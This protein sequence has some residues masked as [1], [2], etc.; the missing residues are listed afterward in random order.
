MSVW[1]SPPSLLKLAGQSLLRDEALAIAALEELPRELFPPLFT[2]AFF[3]RHSETLKAMVQAW[4]FPCLPLGVLMKEQQPHQETF[5]AVLDGLD[6]LLAQEV[7]P[8]RWKLQLLDLRKNTHQD[9]WTVW[10]GTKGSVCSLLD[11]EAA[12]PMRKKQKVGDLCTGTEQPLAPVEVLI[13]LALGEGAQDQLLTYLIEK[14]KQRKGLLQL[15]CRKLEIFAMPIHN[16]KMIL[17]LVQLDSIK[18]LEVNCTWKLSTLGKFSPHLGQMS[19]LQ[20]LLLSHV[21]MS[22]SMSLEE[23]EQ[24]VAQFT[25]QFLKLHHLQELYLDS[26]SFLKGRLHQLLRCLKSPLETLSIS[27]CQ[28]SESD[29]TCLSQCPNISQLKELGLSGVNLTNTSPEPLQVLLERTSA[30]LQDLDLDECGI[31][32]AQFITILPTLGRCS[33]LTTFSFCGNP[34]SMAVLESLL[35]YTVG[36]SKLSHVLYPA[37][38]ESY[39]DVRGTLH[40]GRLAHLHAKLKR[41]LHESGR[42]G[43]VWFS[44]NPCP[45]C[46][47]RTVYD[48]EPVLCP[49]FMPI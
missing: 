11:A 31:M 24:N 30:T 12:Q 19:N 37:P 17:N 48:P 47:D 34:I 45:H 1:T 10:S 4:P 42:P 25:S 38:L 39:E 21:H 15:C 33:Q 6:G 5:W 44:A 23:E 14:V 43:M 27:N 18:D 20:R 32:D 2:T 26:V 49:C 36:L 3:G 41:M 40:L 8:R 9:F 22:S 46:G 7:R 28:L 35:H 29:L 16:I 13:D